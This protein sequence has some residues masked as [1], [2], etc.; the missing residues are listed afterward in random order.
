MIKPQLAK[1]LD[2]TPN[3]G[4]VYEPKYDGIRV[5]VEK[6]GDQVQVYTRTLKSQAGKLPALEAAAR[7]VDFDFTLD[8]EVV[9]I[10]RTVKVQGQD[11]PVCEFIGALSALGS[12]T[13]RAASKSKGLMFIAFDC[14]SAQGKDLMDLPDVLRRGAGELLV[15]LLKTLGAPIML[16]PR[17]TDVEPG[18][19]DALMDA[20][21]EAGGEGLMVKNRLSRY[22]PGKRSD[23]WLKMKAVA[24][25]DVVIM[26]YKPGENGFTGLVGAVEFGQYKGGVLVARSRCSGMD[27]AMRQEFTE[28][29]NAY[30]GQVME[31]KYFGTVGDGSFRHPNFLRL[32]PDKAPQDCE[33]E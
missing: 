32:R 31:I 7:K 21:V 12:A 3:K 15:D 9:E 1:A 14:L 19:V 11:V 8:G 23:A 22:Y 24:T 6:T 17:W 28:N 2:G 10:T 27:M 18:D 26:G 13:D 16:T 5:V 30:I 4:S 33:W 20:V 29:G 25:A